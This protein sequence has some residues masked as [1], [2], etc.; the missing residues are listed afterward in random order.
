VALNGVRQESMYLTIRELHEEKKYP[1][2]AICMILKLSRSSYYKWL[3]RGKSHREL[4]NEE[5]ATIIESLHND[6]PE[7]G[8]RRVRDI[9]KRD[10][11]I[12]VSDK[13]TLR[14]MRILGIQ[15]TVKFRRCG[16]TRSASEP[17]YMAENI[18]GRRFYAEIPNEKW[19]TDITEFKYILNNEVHKLYLSAILDL[20]DKRIVSFVIGD[21][22][23]NQIVNETFDAA[24]SANP[25]AHPLFHS[26]RGFQY[27]SK[28]FHQRLVDTKMTQSM[29]RVGCCLD[30]GPMEGFWGILKREKYYGRKFASRE[31]LVQTITDYIDYYNNRRYQRRLFTMTPMEAHTLLIA[32]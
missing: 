30:N 10:H 22:N 15:S 7:L 25:G 27:T 23:N 18:L 14:I 32:A 26:D 29:S 8:H 31:S 2:E 24:V 3:N 16:C 1:V 12:N 11:G 28:Q 4:E 21:R 13:R 9:L 5:I 6:H 20:C 19:L 17:Q